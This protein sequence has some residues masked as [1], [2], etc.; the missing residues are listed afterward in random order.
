[1]Q[2]STIILTNEFG[3]LTV[4]LPCFATVK[5]EP[6]DDNIFMLLD[7]NNK[8]CLAIDL[9]NT[10][11][12]PFRSMTPTPSRISVHVDKTPYTPFY[13]RLA[14]HDSPFQRPPLHHFSSSSSLNIVDAL[15]LTKSRKRS[16]SNLATID[17]DNIDVHNI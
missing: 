4:Q 14:L 9:S 5:L 7:Y 15:K 13:M 11:P 12:F 10:S 2:A 17:F 3:T 1:M 8:I 16:K 6:S